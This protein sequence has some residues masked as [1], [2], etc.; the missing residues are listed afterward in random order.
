[1]KIRTEALA[2]AQQKL[3]S[4]EVKEWAPSLIIIQAIASSPDFTAAQISA[5]FEVSIQPL[6]ISGTALANGLW[7]EMKKLNESNKNEILVSIIGG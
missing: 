4:N 3:L 2:L 1:M 5:Y 6:I 7:N